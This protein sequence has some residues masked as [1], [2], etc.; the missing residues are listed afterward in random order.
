MRNPEERPRQF[1]VKYKKGAEYDEPAVN[2]R[3]FDDEDEPRRRR[4]FS[5]DDESEGKKF[6]ARRTLRDR[7][8]EEAEESR[9]YRTARASR[10]K[11]EEEYDDDEEEEDDR[12]K[13]PRI[14]R[15]FAWVALLAILFTCGYLGANYFF[16]WADKKGGPRVGDVYG[17]GSEVTQA[18]SQQS[19]TTPTVGNATYNLYVPED[20]KIIKRGID[21][22]KGLTEEDIE[23]VATIYIDGLKETNS[24][25]NGVQLLNVFCSGDWLYLDMTSA[26]QKSMQTLGKEKGALVITGLVQTMKENFPPI[27]KIKFYI[28]GKES[29]VKTP[30]D[31]TQPWEIN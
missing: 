4:A 6:F 5:D 18:Q 22:R 21:I 31:L 20:G 11:F 28:D 29:K 9:S 25:D 3:G 16:S 10:R 17:S 26:F 23:K 7:E 27:K 24:L 13:A 8:E 14:V 1:A 2:R 12:R 19:E 30:V 15:V